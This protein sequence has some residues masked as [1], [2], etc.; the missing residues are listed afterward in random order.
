MKTTKWQEKEAV[1]CFAWKADQRHSDED[2][3]GCE[4]AG[5]ARTLLLTGLKNAND[6]V[7]VRIVMS[8]AG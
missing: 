8:S 6:V 2:K 1:D 5:Y 3:G 7:K 4:V